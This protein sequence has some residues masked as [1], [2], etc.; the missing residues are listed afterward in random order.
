MPA[1]LRLPPVVVV[2]TRRW[3]FLFVLVHHFG[4][5]LRWTIVVA[6]FLRKCATRD[7]DPSQYRQQ[8]LSQ[9]THNYLCRLL[10]S[11]YSTLEGEAERRAAKASA[12]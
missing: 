7:Q 1:S 9:L 11:F 8:N 5:V 2:L 10:A 12:S 4:I 3:W 6:T